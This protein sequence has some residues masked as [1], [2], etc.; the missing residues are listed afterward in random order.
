MNIKYILLIL[1]IIGLNQHSF[2][3]ELNANVRVIAPNLQTSDK[4]IVA[5][6]ESSIKEFLNKQKWTSDVYESHEKIKCNFQI[7]ISKDYGNNNFDFDISLQSIRPVFNSSHETILLNIQDKGIPISFDPYKPIENSKESYYDNLSSVLTY[8]AYLIIAFDYESF[9]PEGGETYIRLIENMI[10]SI[11]P[12]IKNI[13]K[14]WNP[15]KGKNN[16]RYYI[17]ENLTNPRFKSFRNAFYDYHRNGMDSFDQDVASARKKIFDAIET[18]QAVN[19]SYPN[20]Y[21]MQI[22][23]QSKAPEL[24]EIFKMGTSIEK[25]KVSQIL[26]QMDPSNAKSYETINKS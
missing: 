16:N 25:Q 18:L 17:I 8:Y 13:D 19:S 4:S 23:L 1:I 15:S 11:P 22:F 5:Q 3:Q 14:G 7:T 6:I 20:S 2:S 26:I 9:S 10:N 12:Q 21:M 24:I